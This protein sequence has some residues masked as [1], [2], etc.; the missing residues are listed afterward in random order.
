MKKEFK[1]LHI[2]PMGQGV[3]KS[4]EEITFI[5]KTLPEETVE[6][7]VFKKK[8]KIQF[9]KLLK[10]K[11][12]SPIRIKAECPHF[13]ACNG[14]D[15][16]H[17]DYTNELTFK[18][19]ALKR[20]LIKYPTLSIN[21]HA[22]PKR[23]YYR[24]RVQLHYDMHKLKLGM[25][26]S[27]FNIVEVP[28]CIIS[29]EDVT[30][31]LKELYKNN[32]WLN[33]AAKSSDKKGHI[34][35]YSHNNQV[36]VS[37][38]QAYAEGGFTQVFPE[39]NEKLINWV[40][41]KTQ[42][43]IKKEEIVF[44]LFGGNGNITKDFSQKTLVVDVYRK[45]PEKT[46]HQTFLSLNLYGKEA[47]NELKNVQKKFGKPEWLIIDPP[48]SGLKNIKEFLDLF[49]P[50]GFI[51][52]ACDPTSFARDCLGVLDQYQLNEIELFDLFPATQHFETVGIFT[53]R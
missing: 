34:E 22:A 43:L 39:M 31:K 51:Y 28:E 4:G 48:R 8:Q 41:E 49:N 53:K 40:L 47:L 25:L 42:S 13:D 29:Q 18:S 14:C 23:F 7:S 24:N 17:T 16:Q 36:K 12:S 37:L 35:I 19:L 50:Q 21:V 33:L 44:D 6:A 9:A 32:N 3:D 45:T 26:D 20:H 10:V 52:I 2:D 1:I 27:E 38:N 5:K 46:D 11:T 30:A 15:F